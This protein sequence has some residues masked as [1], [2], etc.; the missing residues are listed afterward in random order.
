MR[1]SGVR[2]RLG[3]FARLPTELADESTTDVCDAPCGLSSRLNQPVFALGPLL[4]RR[5]RAVDVVGVL[6]P[7]DS[8][9]PSPLPLALAIENATLRALLSRSRDCLREPVPGV[10]GRCDL[11]EDEVAAVEERDGVGGR[12]GMGSPAAADMRS[13]VPIA[14]IC[15]PMA[16]I[17][18]PGTVNKSLAELECDDFGLLLGAWSGA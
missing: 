3:L 18:A 2:G 11:P 14:P 6:S 17:P 12:R 5:T 7:C 8:T 16:R 10:G 4:W 13:C 1:G 9:L 15:I